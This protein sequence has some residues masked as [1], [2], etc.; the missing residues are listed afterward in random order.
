VGPTPGAR[1]C[2]SVQDFD[3]NGVSDE[4]EPGCGTPCLN[5]NGNGQVVAA[6]QKFGPKMWGC[7]G[8]RTFALR[9]SAC[10]AGAVPCGTA[11]WTVYIRQAS[12][13][14]PLRHY[15]VNDNLNYDGN[16]GIGQCWASVNATYSCDPN[17]MRVC[18]LGANGASVTDVD[19][20]VCNWTG[21]T[22]GLAGGPNDYLGGCILNTTA[23][24][25]CC[26]P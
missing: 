4:L 7:A 8:K 5:P 10:T 23:G 26:T 14:K 17:P 15:W 9:A 24:T 19:G 6:A 13:R 25:L 22:S 11:A 12:S 1:S 20:N 3:C 16:Q 2:G 18:A 21:C